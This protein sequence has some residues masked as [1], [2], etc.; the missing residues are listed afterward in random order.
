[1]DAEVEAYYNGFMEEAE[2]GIKEAN[3]QIRGAKEY[4]DQQHGMADAQSQM[5]QVDKA[6][7]D[8]IIGMLK[9]EAM[10]HIQEELDELAEAARKRAEE[11]EEQEKKAEEAKAE[12]TEQEKK[13]EKIME[14]VSEGQNDMEKVQEEIS[15]I[16]KDSDLL[17][18]DQKGILVNQQI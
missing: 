8:E 5:A 7:S 2:K 10:N 12:Q 14:E 9:D 11:K 1:M 13:T 6:G 17:E 18:E 4:L 3:A 15:K 16:L